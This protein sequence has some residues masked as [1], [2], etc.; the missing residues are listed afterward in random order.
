MMGS[1]CMKQISKDEWIKKNK[2]NALQYIEKIGYEEPEIEKNFAEALSKV[3]HTDTQLPYII[4]N[5]LEQEYYDLRK[6]TDSNLKALDLLNEF[7]NHLCQGVATG[8]FQVPNNEFNKIYID[9]IQYGRMTNHYLNDT[10]LS[11][12]IKR[13][14]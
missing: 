6:Q 1:Y 11:Y 14:S 13:N 4:K 10:G 2:E 5:E 7:D 12:S 9:E 8:L 3:I